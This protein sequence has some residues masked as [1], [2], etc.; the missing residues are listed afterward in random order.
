MHICPH[1]QK[2]GISSFDAMGGTGFSRGLVS[3]RYCHNV[4]KRR[5][6]PLFYLGVP[7]G[8]IVFWAMV[9]FVNPPF[10]FVYIWFAFCGYCGLMIV[11]RSVEL[12][13]Y[14]PRQK[15]PDPRTTVALQRDSASTPS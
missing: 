15:L 13:K 9:Y 4:S 11:D 3:C 1:C 2:L 7:M 12:E 14:E 8:M 10:V 5:A 6:G